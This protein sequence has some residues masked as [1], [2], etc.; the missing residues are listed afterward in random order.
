MPKES[1]E[2]Y[3]VLCGVAEMC[4][5]LE[6]STF[7]SNEEIFIIYVK[8]GKKYHLNHYCIEEE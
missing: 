5:E 6:K 1:K 3:Q 2:L 8:D 7:R 4:G